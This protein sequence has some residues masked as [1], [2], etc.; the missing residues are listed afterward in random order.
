MLQNVGFLNGCS[1]I[2]STTNDRVL[3]PKFDPKLR[4]HQFREM[5]LIV[6]KYSFAGCE[7]A[8]LLGIAQVIGV[9]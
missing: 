1:W 4:P 6:G 9:W 8:A 7:P 2:C 5:M 3:G